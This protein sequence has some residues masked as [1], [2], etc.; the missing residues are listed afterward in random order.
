MVAINRRFRVIRG[1][2]VKEEQEREPAT[3][4]EYVEMKQVCID[5]M[6]EKGINLNEYYSQENILQRIREAEAEMIARDVSK[7]QY[8]TDETT[9]TMRQ[10]YDA[11]T[12]KT[13]TVVKSIFKYLK[14]D[15]GDASRKS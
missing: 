6:R 13:K 7:V 3:L 14:R 9:K 15:D 8:N 5:I 2:R 11:V 4:D 12:E 1:G 10:T